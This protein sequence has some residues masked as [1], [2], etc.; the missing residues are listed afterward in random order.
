MEEAM[1][2]VMLAMVWVADRYPEMG[3]K[4][5]EWMVRDVVISC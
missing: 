3:Y 1:M 2:R 5:S 4:D